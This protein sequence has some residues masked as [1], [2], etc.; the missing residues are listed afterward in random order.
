M[1][2][3]Q[4]PVS[5]ESASVPKQLMKQ[6]LGAT[7]VVLAGAWNVAIFRPEWVA[8]K[9]F[10]SPE[11]NLTSDMSLLTTGMMVIDTID[12]SRGI[13]LRLFPGRLEVRPLNLNKDT[14]SSVENVALASLAALPETPITAIGV[15]FGYVKELGSEPTVV[16]FSDQNTLEDLGFVRHA[17]S[18]LREFRKGDIILRVQNQWIPSPP[19]IR[20]DINRHFDLPDL[21]AQSA[22][23]L[24][25]GY[26]QKTHAIV[27]QLIEKLAEIC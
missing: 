10:L 2:D 22:K 15:N 16:S 13:A 24:L 27:E 11:G 6:D 1:N 25:T 26:V 21:N 3:F 12:Q 5:P 9:I 19:Q 17:W 4:P 20:Y 18:T 14:L 8:K 23:G 7:S